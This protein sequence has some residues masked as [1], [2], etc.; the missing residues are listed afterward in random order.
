[1]GRA[2]FAIGAL[3]LFPLTSALGLG[4]GEAKVEST[5]NQQL[6]ARIELVAVKPGDL[7]G[8]TIR[9]ADP[10]IFESAGLARPHQLSQLK[11]EAV[12]TAEDAGHIR[13]TSKDRI[14]EPVLS[15][16][17]EVKWPNGR[18]LREYTFILSAP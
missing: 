14:R 9:L 2:M 18:L 7:S 4:L 5:I 6:E 1:M 8:L 10:E 3:L 17:V 15:F 16:I 12:R 13:V 11:F